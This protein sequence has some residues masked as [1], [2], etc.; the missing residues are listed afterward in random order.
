MFIVLDWGSRVETDEL[1]VEISTQSGRRGHLRPFCPGF[2][3]QHGNI[4]D[5]R[6]ASIPPC[7]FNAINWCICC[8]VVC[9]A[10]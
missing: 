2:R 1:M 5:P 10:Q 4:R 9:G 7:V 6:A 8:A 3:D